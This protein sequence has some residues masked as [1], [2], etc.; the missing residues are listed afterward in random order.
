M[1]AH[2]FISTAVGKLRLD[3][4]SGSKARVIAEPPRASKPGSGIVKFP[5]VKCK[6][7]VFQPLSQFS[8]GFCI[9]G[10]GKPKDLMKLAVIVAFSVPIVNVVL[11]LVGSAIVVPAPET[12]QF[13]K[14][15]PGAGL[16]TSVCARP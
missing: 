6:R 5:P 15:N 14:R 9:G 13:T 11:G 4:V 8:G 1:L 10:G 12:S 16:A 2:V 3:A 7:M